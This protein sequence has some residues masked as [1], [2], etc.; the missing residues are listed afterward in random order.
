MDRQLISILRVSGL[1]SLSSTACIAGGSVQQGSS[2]PL[3]TQPVVQASSDHFDVFVQGSAA[4]LLAERT[5]APGDSEWIPSKE[6]AGGVHIPLSEHASA[7][8]FGMSGLGA[9]HPNGPTAGALDP[10][11]SPWGVGG[12]LS[13]DSQQGP[14]GWMLGAKGMAVVVP[15]RF[16]ADRGASGGDCGWLYDSLC[17]PYNGPVRADGS[18]S[19]VG[20][21]VGLSGGVFYRTAIGRLGLAAFVENR[22]RNSP[23]LREDLSYSI[24]W[25]RAAS[26]GVTLS[27]EIGSSLALVPALTAAV[28]SDGPAVALIPT[29]GL[30]YTL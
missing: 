29:L 8:L 18:A 21:V 27:A 15:G 6:V 28:V 19:E 25:L 14:L 30:R 4:A 9:N 26:G 24:D 16:S 17:T 5:G 22:P 2:I 3:P 11:A 1:A 10:G 12:T 20:Y 23:T 13:F 7:S